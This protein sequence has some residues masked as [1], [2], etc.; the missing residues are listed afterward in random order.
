MTNVYNTPYCKIKS[1][2]SH[3]SSMLYLLFIFNSLSN[4]QKFHFMKMFRLLLATASMLVLLFCGTEVSAQSDYSGTAN[5]DVKQLVQVGDLNLVE[6]A[7]AMEIISVLKVSYLEA[8]DNNSSD[9]LITSIRI[10]YLGELSKKIDESNESTEVVVEASISNLIRVA[11]RFNNV[12]SS[13]LST[14]YNDIVNA[15]EN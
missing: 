4:I 12:D 14:V 8:A 10:A 6:K 15:L 5:L 9:D 3:A 2:Y 7:E 13:T 11:N 1:R